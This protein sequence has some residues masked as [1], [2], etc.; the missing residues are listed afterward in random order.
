[1]PPILALSWHKPLTSVEYAIFVRSTALISK[2]EK[3]EFT[4]NKW[5]KMFLNV[6]LKTRIIAFFEPSTPFWALAR[7]APN[8]KEGAVSAK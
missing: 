8:Q 7:H 6:V 3:G 2:G 4:A 1:M 5:L